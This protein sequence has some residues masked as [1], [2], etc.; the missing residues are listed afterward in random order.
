M[1]TQ[2][3]PA[4]DLFILGRDACKGSGD[5]K[6][7]SDRF[8]STAFTKVY[9][10]VKYLAA[11]DADYLRNQ[12]EGKPVIEVFFIG[13]YKQ[14]S[15]LTSSF[16]KPLDLLRMAVAVAVHTKGLGFSLWCCK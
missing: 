4:F 2:Q 11:T 9:E 16:T 10:V 6:Q 8:L 12:Y 1:Y 13:V 15:C 14:V 5:L 3:I 7:R